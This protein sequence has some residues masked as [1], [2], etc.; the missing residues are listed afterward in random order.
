[1]RVSSLSDEHVIDLISK[2]YVP[3]WYSRDSYQLGERP[4]AEQEEMRRID[5][6]ASGKGGSVCV[7]LLDPD[8]SVLAT[9]LVQSASKP[10]NLIPL[11]RRVIE[12]KKV[13]PRDPAAVRASTAGSRTTPRPIEKDSLV[14]QV[15]TRFDGNRAN[16]GL[17][18]DWVELSATEAAALAPPAETKAGAQWKVP[19]PIAD[20]IYR[21]FYPPGPNWNARGSE[22]VSR[23]LTATTAS[24][25]AD[26]VQIDLRGT[27][28]LSFS[29]AN[30]KD[31]PGEMTAKVVGVARYDRK[32]QAI[33]ALEMITEEGLYVWQYGGKPQP[34]RMTVAVQLYPHAQPVDR[35]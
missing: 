2:Y 25:S 9:Q 26:E 16:Y 27:L 11:L 24:I 19:D 5:R 28:K 35:K 20:K 1:M 6:R 34:E 30:S 31:T 7:F 8:G 15:W 22:V 33:T 4:Q 14:L 13:P 29:F 21:Y 18:Q 3:V 32:H 23:T 10:E 12:E 17:S